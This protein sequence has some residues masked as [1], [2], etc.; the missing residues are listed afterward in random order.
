MGLL[1]PNGAG[2]TTVMRILAALTSAESGEVTVATELLNDNQ[3]YQHQ[4]GYLPE[5]V[6]LYE[7]LSVYQYL[8]YFAR[9]Y[10][11]PNPQ[12]K[13]EEALTD[14]DLLSRKESLVSNLSKGMRQ[15][16]GLARAILPDP[17]ILLLDE[18]TIGLDPAQV[19]DIRNLIRR[20]GENKAVLF[21]THILAEAQQTCDRLII[22]RE[23]QVV[24]DGPV[25]ELA[26]QLEVNPIVT[27]E[28]S[29]IDG[30][31][32]FAKTQPWCEQID[33]TEDNTFKIQLFSDVAPS[34]VLD[35]IV[36]NG[37]AVNQF[38]LEQ[39]DL[40]DIYLDLLTA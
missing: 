15:R 35:T 10:S 23:G 38:A 14:V 7:D 17:A 1:G 22:L 8:A 30:F 32:S 11:L 9:L 24:A 33:Q 4:I 40:E 26:K 21:S 18:P 20:L 3:Q 25:P 2:K 16:L 39:T 6:P 37:F 34:T 29:V 19:V 27:V 28:V 12:A 36:K 5:T 13:I 31:M